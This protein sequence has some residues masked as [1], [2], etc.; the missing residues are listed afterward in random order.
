M[1]KN[2]LKS[3]KYYSEE[4]QEIRRFIIILGSIVFIILAIYI[5]SNIANKKNTYH[6][7]EIKEGVIN[8]DIVTVG[9]MF[10]RPE[11]EYYV[12]VYDESDV[13]SVTYESIL[14][15]YNNYFSIGF[16]KEK[17]YFCDL[18]NKLNEDYVAKSDEKSNPKAKTIDELKLGKFTFLKISKGKITKYI[19]DVELVKTE[20]GIEEG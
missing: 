14:S 18:S 16:K 8:N 20:L 1:K 15:Q 19:E 11:S 3:Q 13:N 10:N 2:V 5:I 6:Y 4:Q 7:D 17:V 9:T 12:I